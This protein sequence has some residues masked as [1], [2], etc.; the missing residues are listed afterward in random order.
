MKSIL[1]GLNGAVIVASVVLAGLFGGAAVA[2]AS[3]DPVISV[4]DGDSGGD[5]AGVDT[6]GTQGDYKAATD[7]S[8]TGGPIMNASPQTHA[9]D[10]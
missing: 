5:G 4:Q 8:N 1:N 10:R 6:D 7:G 2:S 3:T 9:G